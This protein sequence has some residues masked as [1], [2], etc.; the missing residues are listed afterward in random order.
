MTNNQPG[1]TTTYRQT[2]YAYNNRN[3]LTQVTTYD[4]G[5]PE[6]YT[7]YF[8]DKLGNKLRM[9]TGLSQLLTITG[10]DQVSANGD[11]TYAV[12]K[13]D[14]DRFNHLTKYTDPEGRM[15]TYTYDLNKQ[16]TGQ[17]DKN[18]SVITQSYD[19]LGRLLS[20]SVTNAQ[21][22]AMNTVV[23]YT[24]TQTGAPKSMSGGGLTTTYCYDDLGRL[25]KES[26]TNGVETSTTY[27]DND[28]RKTLLIKVGGTTQTNTAYTYDKLNRLSEV[29]ENGVLAASYTYDENG[30]RKPLTYGNGVTTAYEYNLANQLTSLTNKKGSTMLS[31]Y[32]YMYTLDGNQASKTDQS[33]KVTTYTY[34]ELGRFTQEVPAGEVTIRY[35]Y[36]DSSNQASMT[37]GI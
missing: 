16:L 23:S 26:N 18:G 29:R 27:D 32:T 2:D 28:N 24:Y 22:P 19:A 31:D 30:N 17:V 25:I 20:K 3:F 1:E 7:Q 14:Y 4:Q 10:L 35:T 34:D 21:N 36:D 11:T 5:Q 8:Y 15:E 6:T 9:Y 37:V 13:Y 12:T 33:G